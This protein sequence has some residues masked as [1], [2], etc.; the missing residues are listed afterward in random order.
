[1]KTIGIILLMCAAARADMIELYSQPGL[2]NSQ[3]FGTVAITV[4]PLWQPNFPINLIDPSRAVWISYALTGYDDP[5][6]QPGNTTVSV[7]QQ[8]T[9]GA[10]FFMLDVW[11]DNSAKV[12]LDN[13][14]LDNYWAYPYQYPSFE[15]NGFGTYMT[16]VSDGRHEL[17]FNVS[18]DDWPQRNTHE[19]PFGLLY[20]GFAPAPSSAETPEPLTVSLVGL[21]LL[22]V[23]IGTRRA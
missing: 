14:P 8:F 7:Y 23:G 10:G 20:T 21:A 2:P 16:N 3:S 19:N 15:P 17:R 12:F 11:A 18:Q 13:I 5:I 6:Y 1:M 4:D 9:S 22:A